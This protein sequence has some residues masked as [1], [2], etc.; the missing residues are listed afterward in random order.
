MSS[1]LAHKSEGDGS[2]DQ[3]PG[4]LRRLFRFLTQPQK[5][6]V[7]ESLASIRDGLG[8]DGSQDHSAHNHPDRPDDP[9][10]FHA[11]TE[12]NVASTAAMARPVFYAPDMDGQA[13]PGEVVWIW[14]STD[15]PGNPPRERAM[16]VI[17]RTRSTILGLLISCNP[18]HRNDEDWID[19]GA[20]GWDERGRQS[21]VRLDRILEV[22]EL[23]IRR[24]GTVIPQ[25]RFER[26]ANRLRNDFGWA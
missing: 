9:E 11:P 23:G 21:W 16:V 26:I 14:V 22:S 25:G 24:Q 8:I 5:T 19:I 15:G 20:G 3:K 17:G 13:D 7:D 12:I 18:E 2:R 10:S 1:M 4:V 6:K